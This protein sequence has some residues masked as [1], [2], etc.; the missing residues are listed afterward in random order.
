MECC[1]DNSHLYLTV[2]EQLKAQIR[3]GFYRE[4]LPPIRILAEKYSVSESTLKKILSQLKQLKLI[5]G[6]QGKGLYVSHDLSL[7]D[8]KLI[9]ILLPPDKQGNPFYETCLSLI[10]E[11]MTQDSRTV[12]Q[13]VNSLAKIRNYADKLTALIMVEVNDTQLASAALQLVGPA[14]IFFFNSSFPNARS[15]GSDNF[16][17][18]YMAM[19]YLFRCGHR[20]V[21]ILSRDLNIPGC[22][23]DYRYRGALQFAQ[24]HA[25]TIYH[26][27]IPICRSRPD[28][29]SAYLASG[30]LF[31]QGDFTAIFAF[32]DIS[33]LG[34]LSYCHDHHIA[35]PGDISLLGF[36]NR[37][38]SAFLTP[39]LTTIQ[40]NSQALVQQTLSCIQRII[41]GESDML[42][43]LVPPSLIERK[44]VK[45]ITC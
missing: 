11:L 22:I 33:A 26:S 13:V 34:V 5:Y 24:E 43:L 6:K 27:E 42:Q 37:D 17:G 12:I 40:E 20:Q 36:D 4:Q 31:E 23:F 8:E 45:N 18:G 28:Q 44:S 30:K 41:N 9:L 35:I 2:F 19:E 39:P 38:F 14:K 16:A 32:T 15:I 29:Q 1:N 7:L 25:M 3:S 10:Q 21:G